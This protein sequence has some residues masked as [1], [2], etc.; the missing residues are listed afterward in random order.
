M[1]STQALVSTLVLVIAMGCGPTPADI[2]NAEKHPTKSEERQASQPA[3]AKQEEPP[4]APAP[5]P[6]N[7][8]ASPTRPADS[9][10]ESGMNANER[11]AELEAEYKL[12]VSDRTCSVD[13]DCHTIR[14]DC[15]I[16]DTC[17][18]PVASSVSADQVE[19]LHRRWQKNDCD[20]VTASKMCR[21][22]VH[23]PKSTCV[24]N[25]CTLP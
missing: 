22:A 6:A 21:C 7:E 23:P 18:H 8:D 3:P 1:P 19:R 15:T 2:A 16:A 13:S 14:A 17:W 12:V 10:E 4:P 24:N 25:H 9:T 5:A 20:R 11:C